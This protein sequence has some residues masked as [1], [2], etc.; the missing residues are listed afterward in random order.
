MFGVV[1]RTVELCWRRVSCGVGE[2]CGGD[3]SGSGRCV[4]GGVREEK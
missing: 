3:D 4:G 2:S 1:M